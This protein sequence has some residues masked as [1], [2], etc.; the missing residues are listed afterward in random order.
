M[1][2]LRTETGAD[3]CCELF[4][5]A[6]S[7]A[8]LGSASASWSRFFERVRRVLWLKSTHQARLFLLGFLKY[9]FCGIRVISRPNL[10]AQFFLVPLLH[11]FYFSTRS[12]G[13]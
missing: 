3:L 11:L 7:Q 12:W 6:N 13:C 4:A 1:R 10:G 8:I 5:I 9:L 2:R